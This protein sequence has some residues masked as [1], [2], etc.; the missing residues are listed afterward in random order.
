MSIIFEH[1][2]TADKVAI[3]LYISPLKD[4]DNKY[5][6]VGTIWAKF[7]IDDDWYRVRDIPIYEPQYHKLPT[8]HKHIALS[9]T[10]E[11]NKDC[12]VKKVVPL[13]KGVAQGMIDHAESES[14]EAIVPTS[15]NERKES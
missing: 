12:E 4:E 2:N 9:V 6:Y 1:H 11:A 7:D 14:R 13:F 8:E 3:G 5:G 15:N 10:T